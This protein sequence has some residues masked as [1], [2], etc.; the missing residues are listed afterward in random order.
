MVGGTRQTEVP[1]TQYSIMASKSKPVLAADAGKK[2]ARSNL[3]ADFM[4]KKPAPAPAPE[5]DADAVV[6]VEDAAEEIRE[7]KESADAT[8]DD[9]IEKPSKGA[10]ASKASKATTKPALAV[11]STFAVSGNEKTKY[12]IHKIDPQHV[13]KFPQSEWD[14]ASL[15]GGDIQAS[16]LKSGFGVESFVYA[17]KEKAAAKLLITFVLLSNGELK[18]LSQGPGKDKDK[19]EKSAIAYQK[20]LLDKEMENGNINVVSVGTGKSKV[21]LPESTLKKLRNLDKKGILPDGSLTPLVIPE[22]WAH[23]E[24]TVKNDIVVQPN[25]GGKSKS[26]RAAMPAAEAAAASEDDP[27]ASND[28]DDESSSKKTKAKR[29]RADDDEEVDADEEKKEKKAE[30]PAKKVKTE[31]PVAKKFTE[32]EHQRAEAIRESCEL[33][34]SYN[35]ADDSVKEHFLKLVF[36]SLDNAKAVWE[37]EGRDARR[38]MNRVYWQLKDK[39]G[40]ERNKA[41]NATADK[42][43]VYCASIFIYAL[44]M[45]HLQYAQCDFL[46]GFVAKKWP[47]PEAPVEVVAKPPKPAV[48]KKPAPKAEDLANGDDL[49]APTEM[50]TPKA[51]ATPSIAARAKA[52]ADEEKAETDAATASAVARDDRPASPLPKDPVARA[53]ATVSPAKKQPRPAP[54]PAPEA[55]A[56]DEAVAPAPAPPVDDDVPGM[57]FDDY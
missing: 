30:P 34:K 9:S 50:K 24:S 56:D 10:K 1:N 54:A 41:A 26:Q 39:K 21:T 2:A 44:N 49:A 38:F 5:E 43:A 23:V 25:G 31:T 35:P 3:L 12:E 47:A 13:K 29:K 45:P 55:E 18:Y 32:T 40:Q 11:G 42:N 15:G 16:L 46:C 53:V 33:G 57:T 37:V 27:L 20:K 14:E 19:S 28:K 17:F 6:D 22:W 4:K 52:N 8:I 7:A 48:P 36:G 51:V